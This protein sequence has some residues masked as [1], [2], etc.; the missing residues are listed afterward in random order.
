MGEQEGRS[1]EISEISIAFPE[2]PALHLRISVG[3]C[4]LRVVPAKGDAWVQG[5]YRHPKATLPPKIE[6]RNGTVRVSQEFKMGD[7]R[8]MV[9]VPTFELALGRAKAYDL[10]VET[11]ASESEIDLG[12]LPVRRLDIR[13]GAG[14]LDVDFSAPN[15]RR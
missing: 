9:P 10:T 5:T 4:R 7:W 13:Q 2:A 3:A 12:G 11:G 1:T 15:P 8:G 6:E 14:R